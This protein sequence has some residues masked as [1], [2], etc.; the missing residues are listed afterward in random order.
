MPVLAFHQTASLIGMCPALQHCSPTGECPCPCDYVTDPKCTC[1]NLAQKLSVGV[2]KSAVYA[3]YPMNYI[4]R[5]N[6][7]PNEVS[8]FVP[9]LETEAAGVD[10]GFLLATLVR[11][12]RPQCQVAVRC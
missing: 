4:K 3:T 7:R 1:R 2:T 6:G 8:C 5:F 11:D 10:P 9:E 12:S